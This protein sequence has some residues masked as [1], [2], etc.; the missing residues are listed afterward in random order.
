MK[1]VKE[2]RKSLLDE[3]FKKPEV[4]DMTILDAV[5]YLSENMGKSFSDE[6]DEDDENDACD[7][8]RLQLTFEEQKSLVAK[9]SSY[10]NTNEIQTFIFCGL[11]SFQGGIPME[12][13]AEVKLHINCRELIRYKKDIQEMISRG[14]IVEDVEYDRFD[15]SVETVYSVS[16]ESVECISEEKPLKLVK[17][18][19]NKDVYAFLDEVDSAIEKNRVPRS[20]T[21]KDLKAL[22]IKYK[23]EKYI[24]DMKKAVPK[25]NERGILY[26]LSAARV[27]DC[28]VNLGAIIR[29]F[30]ESS[31]KSGAK[32]QFISGKHHLQESNLVEMETTDFVDKSEIYITKAGLEILLGEDAMCFTKEKTGNHSAILPEKI[33]EKELFYPNEIQSQLDTIYN[34][35]NKENFA[36]LQERLEK[37]GMH[38]GVAVLFHGDPGTGKTESVLQIAKKTGRAVYQ[39]D[40]SETKT[41]WFGESERLTKRIFTEYKKECESAKR[42]KRGLPILFLNEADAIIS[43]RRNIGENSSGPGQTENALQNIFLEEIENLEGILIATTNLAT[44]MDSAFDRRFLF[45]VKFEKPEVSVRAKIWQSKLTFLS[46]KDAVSLA[47]RFEFSGGQ[48]DNIARK[49]EIDEVIS[50]VTPTL[51]C[52]IEMCEHEVL[53]G[54][55]ER[56]VGFVA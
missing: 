45:K 3:Y 37:K 33:S 56:R 27:Q 42:E 36:A 5:I 34:A 26:M 17:P 15:G 9:V 38:K 53:G 43:K 28:S 44:N 18:S 48:I 20:N 7:N 10:L 46:E 47:E 30:Y 19:K 54:E 12:R 2:N 49:I 6:E 4:K 50:G 22:E 51:A 40:I 16:P 31:Q 32:Q 25:E 8:S 24:K 55:C 11:F 41:M 29:R 52:I 13:V 14:L 39:V 23:N 1:E 35:L 21:M